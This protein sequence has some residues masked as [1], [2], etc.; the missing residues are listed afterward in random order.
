MFSLVSCYYF[1]SRIFLILPM[2]I[3]A[4]SLAG[5]GSPLFFRSKKRC[6]CTVSHIQKL[7][8]IFATQ[9]VF[10]YKCN[11]TN[12]AFS[13]IF[14]KIFLSIKEQTIG[15]FH[16]QRLFIFRAPQRGVCWRGRGVSPLHRFFFKILSRISPFSKIFFLTLLNIY[17][18]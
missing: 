9:G 2:G 12:H 5:D 8:A 10:F 17:Q 3:P 11:N 1:P 4:E 6:L 15:P 7:R 14:S 18:R 13:A 16:F